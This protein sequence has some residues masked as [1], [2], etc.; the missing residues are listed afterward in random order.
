M[1]GKRLLLAGAFSIPNHQPRHRRRAYRPASATCGATP[2]S[3]LARWRVRVGI[4][5]SSLASVRALGGRGRTLHEGE[6]T[7]TPGR[8]GKPAGRRS[9]EEM[10][11][12]SFTVAKSLAPVV[13]SSGA[14]LIG[15]LLRRARRE[16]ARL[17]R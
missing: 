4:P 10:A 13:V 12:A 8:E 16:Q 5:S 11:A 15:S 9:R 3:C 6:A 14:F 7:M 1:G 17:C 2:R